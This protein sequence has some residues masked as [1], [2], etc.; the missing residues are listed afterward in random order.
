MEINVYELLKG[1]NIDA[2]T[3][4]GKALVSILIAFQEL[5]SSLTRLRRLEAKE[6]QEKIDETLKGD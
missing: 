3:P 6:D 5:E 1:M 4:A 2:T